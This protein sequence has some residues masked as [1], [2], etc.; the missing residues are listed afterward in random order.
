MSA[1]RAPLVIAVAVF[2]LGLVVG[3]ALPR[4]SS[5]PAGVPAPPAAGE[6]AGP[7]RVRMAAQLRERA[8]VRAVALRRRPLAPALDLVGA[9]EFDGDRFAEVGSRIAGRVARVLVRT[10]AVVGAGDPL[11]EIESTEVGDVVAAYIAARA[12][13]AAAQSESVRLATLA[14]QQ[15]TTA[16][17]VEQNRAALAGFEAAI[18]R[19]SQQLRAMGLGPADVRALSA[20]G[21][22]HR[23]TLRAPIAGKVVERPVVLGQVVE[24]T[25]TVLR[26]ADPARL[27]VQLQVFDRDL[28]RV[29]LGDAAEITSEAYVDRTFRGVVGHVGAS[30]DAHTRTARVRIEVDN[31][32]EVLRP[33]Q[34]VTARLRSATAGARSALT[35]PGTAIVQVEGRPAAFVAVGADEF[36]LRYLELGVTDGPEVEVRRGV[37]EGEPV[38]VAGAFALKSELQ[39]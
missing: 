27:W 11:V 29:Q 32:G 19:A 21:R 22:L 18:Q 28:P 1:G 3:R 36:E 9:V 13:A 38:V 8:G 24:P 35:L 5:A 6:Q 25:T 30:L 26:I 34:F 15:L 23:V 31:A 33:G 16:R 39:R 20:G 7:R 37:D 2:G 14:R 10:G 12:S 4:G 17:E